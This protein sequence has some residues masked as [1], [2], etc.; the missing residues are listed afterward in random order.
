MHTAQVWLFSKDWAT[1]RLVQRN[2]DWRIDVRLIGPGGW[3]AHRTFTKPP[4]ADA[5]RQALVAQLETAGFR[6]S[7]EPPAS[8][9]PPV[10]D[11]RAPT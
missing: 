7:W 3:R 9:S 2:L 1:V 4:D 6:L 5:F 11:R 10:D 8:G